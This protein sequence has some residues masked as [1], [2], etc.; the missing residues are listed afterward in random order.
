M[1]SYISK[2]DISRRV[3]RM[4]SCGEF[5]MHYQPQI[6]L[7]NDQHLSFE[8]LLRYKDPGGK[9]LPPLFIQD[10]QQLGAMK[11][12]D[13]M[14]IDL[15]LTDMQKMPL[16]SGCKVAINIS[17]ETISDKHIVAYIVERLSF[18]NIL[19][20]AL[21]IEITEE[22]II[23]DDKGVSENIAVLQALGITVA[24]D[25]FGSGYASFPHLLKFNFDKVKLDRSLLFNIENE[26]EKTY[27]NY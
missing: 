16:E 11:Q 13:K 4:L 6:N 10:F 26:R 15:V 14:V 2:H 20:E 1:S 3:S 21:E 23:V 22:V 17:A 24:I 25:D 19:P 18:F 7:N 8:A 12:L 27:I 5:M 9:L